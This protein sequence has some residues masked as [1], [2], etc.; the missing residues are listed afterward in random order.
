[1]LLDLSYP[2]SVLPQ[3]VLATSICGTCHPSISSSDA[4]CLE[5]TSQRSVCNHEQCFIDIY[6]VVCATHFMSLGT[7]ACCLVLPVCQTGVLGYYPRVLAKTPASRHWQLPLFNTDSFTASYFS[8]FVYIY[9]FIIFSV[10]LGIL[11]AGQMPLCNV[12]HKQCERKIFCS[13]E[14]Q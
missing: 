6:L 2:C 10:H 1:M 5:I 8:L 11:L 7:N 12:F 9:V 14:L 4:E 13:G 3:F